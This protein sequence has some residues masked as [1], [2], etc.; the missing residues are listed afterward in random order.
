[1]AKRAGVRYST[2]IVIVRRNEGLANICGS[3]WQE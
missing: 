1:M 3:R 2:V